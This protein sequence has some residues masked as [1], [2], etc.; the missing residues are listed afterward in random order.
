MILGPW[1]F[2]A[3]WRWKSL[4]DLSSHLV[5]ICECF[6]CWTPSDPWKKS[7]IEY[8]AWKPKVQKAREISWNIYSSHQPG[9]VSNLFETKKRWKMGMAWLKGPQQTPQKL[10]FYTKVGQEASHIKDENKREAPNKKLKPSQNSLAKK[11]PNK[12]L[13]K[14]S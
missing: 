1:C 12:Q 4:N 10:L 2:K 7:F 8:S 9:T 14:P 6:A 5:P 11:K 3:L 13:L